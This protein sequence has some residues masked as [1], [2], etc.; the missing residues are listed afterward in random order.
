MSSPDAVTNLNSATLGVNMPI[1]TLPSGQK[2]P[3]GT[4][5]T[6]LVNVKKYDTLAAQSGD[7]TGQEQDEIKTQLK[8]LEATF[9]AALPLLMKFGMFDLFTPDERITDHGSPGRTRV[10]KLAKAHQDGQGAE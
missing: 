5:G 6:L 3:T 8:E 9:N 10:G 7:A 2:M 1:I 4:I